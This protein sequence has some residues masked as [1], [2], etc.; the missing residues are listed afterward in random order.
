MFIEN[1]FGSKAVFPQSRLNCLNGL[2]RPFALR[3][4]IASGFAFI[5]MYFIIELIDMIH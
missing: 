4:V 2:T 5:V 1:I 3:P